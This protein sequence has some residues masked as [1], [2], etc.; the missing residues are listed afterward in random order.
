[1]DGELYWLWLAVLNLSP[2]ARCAVMNRFGTPEEAFQSPDGSF[3][4][5]KGI[6]AREAELLE[7]R[8]TRIAAETLA[9]CRHDGL[10]ILPIT[11]PAYPRRL[12]EIAQPPA[13]LFVEG[14]LPEV[15]ELPVIAVIGT[16]KASAYG[17]KMGQ[18]LAYEIADGG[19]LVL[20]ML[21]SG[22]DEA[23][24]RGAL[25]AG[26][27]CLAVLG[28]SHDA[29]THP[30][31][32]D[33][34]QW[35][36]LIS[37]YPPCREQNRHFFR[38]R[39]RIG[40][41]LSVGVTV[42]EA[43]EKSGTRLFVADAV[44]QGKDVFAV[45]G[46]ADAK[47]S[48]GTL[49]LLKEGAK[50]VTCGREVLEDY[51]ALFPALTETLKE[52][53]ADLLDRGDRYD[54]RRREEDS[55]E[56]AALRPEEESA[57]GGDHRDRDSSKS[58]PAYV[59]LTETEATEKGTDIKEGKLREQLKELTED[60]L[61]IVGAIHPGSSHIDD[62]AE[63]AGLTTARVLAQLTLLEIKGLV[64]REAGRRFSLNVL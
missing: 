64:R 40:A 22:V 7:A 51:E 52:E 33:I 6:S 32:A 18:E 29:C 35:G 62:I 5:M 11:D 12:K 49:S 4:G 47:N 30:L 25:M 24:A 1:M 56:R 59:E 63:E 44:E 26:R 57:F 54:T 48:A 23:A 45:P 60:Q 28:T 20:S 38:E 36:A 14:I 31:R 21:T 50:L 37:E 39:N 42:I 58:G 13:V 19:G 2:K 55:S 61:K 43:P 27:P 17:I 10:Q 8:Q 41:G 53:R 16:R 46:N 34:R 9:R 15:D 3:R